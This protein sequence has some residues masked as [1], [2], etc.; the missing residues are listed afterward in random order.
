MNTMGVAIGDYDRDLDLDL[1]LSNIGEQKLMRNDAGVFSNVADQ[2]R[3]ER[4]NVLT[5]KSI[6]WG[7]VFSDLNL[8]GWEDLYVGAGSLKTNPDLQL[9]E[10]LVNNH[11][12]KFNDMSAATG[13]A[14]TGTSRGVAAADYDD[15]GR[16]DIYVVNQLGEPKLYRNITA[17]GGSHWLAVDLQGTTSNRDGCGAWVTLTST[18]GDQVRHAMC[19][20]SF[21]SGHDPRLHFGLG[22]DTQVRRVVVEWPSGATQTVTNPGIDKTIQVVESS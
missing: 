21:A 14:D 15:D 2:A 6:T 10:V 16:I 4:E 18:S 17:R 5:N 1:M 12:G 7:L 11:K 22:T 3:V 19:G 20:S 13:A 8:D 9:N